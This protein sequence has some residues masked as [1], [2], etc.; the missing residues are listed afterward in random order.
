MGMMEVTSEG[1][2]GCE[3]RIVKV[4][5]FMIWRLESAVPTNRTESVVAKQRDVT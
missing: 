1:R 2:P 5:R 4:S 3:E